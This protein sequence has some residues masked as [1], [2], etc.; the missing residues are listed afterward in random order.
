[1]SMRLVLI[2][3]RRESLSVMEENGRVTG[4][5]ICPDMY[6]GYLS[7]KIVQEIQPVDRLRGSSSSP[8]GQ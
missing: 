3:D 5:F 2:A 6:A 4:I 8:Q 7:R 1:L